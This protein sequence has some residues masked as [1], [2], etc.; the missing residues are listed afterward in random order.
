M[1][2]KDIANK[3]QYIFRKLFRLSNSK[4]EYDMLQKHARSLQRNGVPIKKKIF[5]T[6]FKIGFEL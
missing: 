1:Q 6:A 4:I 3:N 5:T 2:R